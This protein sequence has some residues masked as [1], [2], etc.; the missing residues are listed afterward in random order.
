MKSPNEIELTFNYFKIQKGASK[1]AG[2]QAQIYAYCT[3]TNGTRF[4]F[5]N[6]SARKIMYF[7][8]KDKKFKTVIA[9]QK[10]WKKLKCDA[11]HANTAE[12]ISNFRQSPKVIS[13]IELV[14]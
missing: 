3:D 9:Y 12:M 1:Y 10:H 6:E 13:G 11:Y 8:V 7:A 2:D 14:P 5:G 4:R